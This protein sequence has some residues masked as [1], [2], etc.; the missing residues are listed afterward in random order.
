L[1]IVLHSW[2]SGRLHRTH[3]PVGK[4]RRWFKSNWMHKF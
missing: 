2:Q 4:T 1:Y 3:N